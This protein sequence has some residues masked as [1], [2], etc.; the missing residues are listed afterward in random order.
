MSDKLFGRKMTCM[1]LNELFARVHSCF[2]TS[3]DMEIGVACAVE[4]MS[5]EKMGKDFPCPP[6]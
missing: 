3:C 5:V 6:S 4:M 1:L 2:R